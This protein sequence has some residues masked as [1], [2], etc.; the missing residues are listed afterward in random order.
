MFWLL[1][2]LKETYQNYH[3]FFSTNH[4]YFNHKSSKGLSLSQQYENKSAIKFSRMNHLTQ[5]LLPINN[6]EQL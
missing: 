4:C 3:L 5:H 2:T 1:K 6:W